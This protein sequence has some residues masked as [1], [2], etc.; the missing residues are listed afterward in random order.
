MEAVYLVKDREYKVASTLDV[1]GHYEYVRS[2]VGDMSEEEYKA[3]MNR[4]E[5]LTITSSGKL[6]GF[7]YYYKTDNGW[8]GSS[9]Y[10]GDVLGMTL[11]LYTLTKNLGFINIKF[12]PHS[13]GV[14]QTKSLL[15]GSSIRSFYCG[16]PYVVVCTEQLKDKV[17][18]ILDVYGVVL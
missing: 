1:D 4:S 9:I 6:L 12:T 3:V 14:F 18:K 17:A 10:G 13:S 5:C 15:V 16:D 7:L 2:L 11:L 8:F